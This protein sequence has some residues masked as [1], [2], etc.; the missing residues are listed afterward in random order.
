MTAAYV[1]TSRSRV[2]EVALVAVILSIVAIAA[3]GGAVIEAAKRWSFQ[4]EYSH[5]FLIPLVTIWLLWT[6]R[7]A[8]AASIGRPSWIGLAAILVAMLLHV[9]G[10]L[11]ALFILSQAS[12]ILA[13][14][15]VVLS[16]GGISL[17]RVAFVPIAFL[18]FAIPLPYFLDSSLSW[19]LQLIS[20]ELG[21]AFIRALQI[22]VFLEGN[23]IDLGLYKLQVVE[24]CSGLRYLYPLLSL[25][26]LVACLFQAPL[27]QR[28][29]V[30][31]SAIPITIVMN[32]LRILLVAIL[33]DRWGPGQAEGLL[34]LFEGWII[35][36]A[37]A[38]MLVGVAYLLTWLAP[39]RPFRHVFQP[40]NVKVH[41]AD[42]GAPAK[43]RLYSA[44][45]L[46]LLCALGLS[47]ILVSTRQEIV[48][49]RMRF[50]L[51][52][53]SVGAWHGRA[54]SLEPQT[55]HFLGLTDYVLSDYARA[56]GRSVNLYVAYY[57]SQRSGVSPHSP[58]VCIP[59]SGWQITHLDR[60]HYQDP[61]SGLLLPLNRAVIARESDRQV[62]YYWFEQR[63]R[64]VANEYVS[65]WH[66]LKDAIYL[67][68]TDGA[69]VRLTTPLYPGE[70]LSDADKRLQNFASELL[71]NL[72]KFL[73]RSPA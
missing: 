22:P 50:V 12:L 33:V 58:Q 54:S 62:V 56:D 68:R 10:G 17:L 71:P 55:E 5:G 66:L 67:N 63:G 45:C 19:R 8:L 34:H 53:T 35:F 21:V 39:N 69:L 20:S 46:L 9:I 2:F 26:F 52:P 72:T 57:A 18:A 27:W 15:G 23:I 42:Q 14:L 60:T 44:A 4:E 49:E 73:P 64:R 36:L 61:E 70:D 30:F 3:F 48:P 6:R 29:I 37:C 32:S 65:K 59:G 31:L 24:A 38:G 13:L 43:R 1:T 47:G 16:V 51:F 40:P 7:E 28:I 25:G 41:A 11:S